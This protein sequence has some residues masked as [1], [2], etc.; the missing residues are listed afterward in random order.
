MVRQSSS[1][2]SRGAA[3]RAGQFPWGHIEPGS[4][5]GHNPFGFP[6]VTRLGAWTSN[7]Q[8]ATATYIMM[9]P[10]MASPVDLE[11]RATKE[12]IPFGSSRSLYTGAATQLAAESLVW[13][14]DHSGVVVE[15]TEGRFHAW[16]T[17]LPRPGLADQLAIAP[18]ERS[19][20]PG[21]LV[22]FV[23]VPAVKFMDS[24]PMTDEPCFVR[25]GPASQLPSTDAASRL[26]R[27]CIAGHE[28]WNRWWQ[29]QRPESV[30][31]LPSDLADRLAGILAK[32]LGRSRREIRVMASPLEMPA[33]QVALNPFD[34]HSLGTGGGDA[35]S[36]ADRTSALRSGPDDSAVVLRISAAALGQGIPLLGVVQTA[37][38]EA[39]HY[40]H[41]HH[42]AEHIRM[43]RR[44]GGLSDPRDQA[45][46]IRWMKRRLTNSEITRAELTLA[47]SCL[48]WNQGTHPAA[49]VEAF[50]GTY[51]HYPREIS[52]PARPVRL[53]NQLRFNPL[54]MGSPHWVNLGSD[55]DNLKG[56]VSVDEPGGTSL[57]KLCVEAVA[58]HAQA[59]GDCRLT[60][61]RQMTT[62][63]RDRNAA[64]S[65]SKGNAA[66]P[67]AILDRLT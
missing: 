8:V 1:R 24:R 38:H 25:E 23:V 32:L 5:S 27:E 19:P 67:A 28:E 33:D 42:A 10:R 31:P 16:E 26:W 56:P 53:G 50:L 52:D 46:F 4:S 47:L 43:W 9:E 40:R 3:R 13:G 63:A 29:T 21:R 30:R 39:A 62:E 37:L 57:R 7:A 66:F 55:G 49:Q 17:S 41:H 14:T 58:Q 44:R 60:D 48:G 61:V 6:A 34:A 12:I 18:V 54:L 20:L 2:S 22:G 15:D 35:R 64:S 65:M 59:E 45:A 36:L 11:V 51:R